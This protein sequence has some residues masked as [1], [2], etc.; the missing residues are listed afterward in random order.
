MIGRTFFNYTNASGHQFH[1]LYVF[2]QWWATKNLT[3]SINLQ[4]LSSLSFL[5]REALS[6]AEASISEFVASPKLYFW[7]SI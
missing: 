7:A 6:I 5:L 1:K 4:G 2:S 3:F